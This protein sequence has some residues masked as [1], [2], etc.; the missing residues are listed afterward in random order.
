MYAVEFEAQAQDQLI[1][2]PAQFNA[3][4][5]KPLRVIVMLKDNLNTPI[6]QQTE[7]DL[8][9]GYLAMASDSER[10]RDAQQWCN[11]L[12]PKDIHATW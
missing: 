2:I 5:S 7:Q 3:L 4:F 9:A 11:N 10:E 1:E 6:H 12:M 8:D